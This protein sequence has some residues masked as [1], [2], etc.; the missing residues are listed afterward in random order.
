MLLNG[1][2]IRMLQNPQATDDGNLVD[3]NILSELSI[4][5]AQFHATLRFWLSPLAEVTDNDR[6]TGQ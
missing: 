6:S 5:D 3:K 2:S 1:A 4:F